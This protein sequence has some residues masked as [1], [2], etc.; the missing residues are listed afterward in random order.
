M[1]ERI[2][3]LRHPVGTFGDRVLLVGYG[4]PRQ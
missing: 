3:T 4:R 2:A 1:T